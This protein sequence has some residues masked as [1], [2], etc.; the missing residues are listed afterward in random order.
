MEI[1]E[2]VLRTLIMFSRSLP[3]LFVYLVQ[4]CAGL[5]FHVSARGQDGLRHTGLAVE[6]QTPHREQLGKCFDT[7]PRV[8]SDETELKALQSLRQ[9]RSHGI[10]TVSGNHLRG[11]QSRHGIPDV[12]AIAHQ[13]HSEAR[14]VLLDH[15][16]EGVVLGLLVLFIVS[17][18]RHIGPRGDRGVLCCW[19]AR[20]TVSRLED[21]GVIILG[22]VVL[23]QHPRA[24]H[25][26]RPLE[27]SGIVGCRTQGRGLVR[28]DTSVSEVQEIEDLCDVDCQ[29]V[30]RNVLHRELPRQTEDRSHLG[31]ALAEDAVSL[32]GFLEL[33][34]LRR[35]THWVPDLHEDRF[36]KVRQPEEARM[37]VGDLEAAHTRRQE[38]TLW[39]RF[40]PDRKL[41]FHL[42]LCHSC[43]IVV[44]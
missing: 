39:Q 43:G 27:A 8:G 29:V 7:F 35:H 14:H 11:P 4:L 22:V 23:Q 20:G 44:S 33:A 15:V 12:E 26:V 31:D 16:S 37:G 34:R 42:W 3:S 18:F 24:G 30:L 2:N 38:R 13:G 6:T 40:D 36:Q 21:L 9:Q 17:I 10:T 19:D 25:G 1:V 32:Y 41:A 28:G 5:Q